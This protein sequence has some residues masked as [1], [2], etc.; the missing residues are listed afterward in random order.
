MA[1]GN[2]TIVY[3]GVKDPK[4]P[5]QRIPAY[6]HE[7][8]Q[9]LEIAKP[10]GRLPFGVP[11]EL[12]M[13]VAERFLRLDWY[14]DAEVRRRIEADPIKNAYFRPRVQKIV[15][16]ADSPEVRDLVASKVAE[17]EAAK[18]EK[19]KAELA[20]LEAKK[21]ARLTALEAKKGAAGKGAASAGLK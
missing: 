15:F 14:D 21:L 10:G 7:G 13:H 5:G 11:V 9:K 2:I 1:K 8:V 4:N 12:P 16:L 20:A 6:D 19:M 3:A 17:V 18:L